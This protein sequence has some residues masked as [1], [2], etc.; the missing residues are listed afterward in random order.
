MSE[1]QLTSETMKRFRQAYLSAFGAQTR[2]DMLY[3]T[4]SEGRRHPGY[5]HWLPLFYDELDTILTYTGNAPLIL[6][7]QVK[8]AAGRAARP[9]RRLLR[10]PEDPRMTRHPAIP[11]TSRSSRRSLYVTAAEWARDARRAAA[12][13]QITP[14]AQPESARTASSSIAA[15]ATG[16]SFAPERAD[17]SRNVFEAAADH[18]RALQQDG[19][20]VILAGWS[21]GSRERLAE[22]S[23]R[24]RSEADGAGL[25]ADL[26]AGAAPRQ[27]GARRLRSRT[28]VRGRGHRRHQ[29]AGHSRRSSRG[30]PKRKNAKRAAN[31]LSEIGSLSEGD[32][33]VH[34]NHGIGRFT[35]LQPIEAGG[36]PHDCLALHYADGAKLYLP[37]ENLELLSRYGSEDTDVQLDRLGGAGW[38]KRKARMRKRVLEMAAGLIKI[39][40][41]RTL[42]EA[43]KLVPPGRPLRGIRGRLSLRRDRGSARHDRGGSRRHGVGPADGPSRLRRRRLRQDRGSRSARLSPPR[44]TASRS[45]SSCRR[46]CSRAS[47]SRI[48]RTGSR[49]CR[50]MSRSCRAWSARPI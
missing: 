41:A 3:E 23:R 50:S 33:V 26:C 5:E 35:G 18:V 38:Q 42:K 46:P 14:H 48:S 31:F 12:S 10:G 24:S 32:I 1:V 2:G 37:V 34:A 17:E 4:I 43:A 49:T 22:R 6:D 45:R 19:K 25:V 16:R 40:A 20:H 7:A 13:V 8:E 9:D 11:P 21:D 29:R 30:R 15:A 28:G 47:T 36:V 27:G 44:S 39:A